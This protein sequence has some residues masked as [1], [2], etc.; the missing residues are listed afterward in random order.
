MLALQQ[1]QRA[2]CA[3]CACSSSSPA[4][5]LAHRP[6]RPCA[7]LAAQQPKGFGGGPSSPSDA[8][9][10]NTSGAGQAAAEPAA[11]PRAAAGAAPSA[12][13]RDDAAL[14]ALEARLKSR[15]AAAANLVPRVKVE[16]AA[17]KLGT[18]QAPGEAGGAAETLYVQF[19]GALFVL[20]LVE[21][22]VLAASVRLPFSFA[23]FVCLFRLPFSFAFFVISSVLSSLVSS[24]RALRLW[25]AHV[26]PLRAPLLTP[27]QPRNT[28]DADENN[29]EN[30]TTKTKTTQ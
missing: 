9:A 21:G 3:A 24:G 1:Q 8:A 12:A 22:L 27:S 19:L 26:V 5:L 6:R 10:P 4:S 30:K 7:R 14:E 16:S 11:K 15:R 18:G 20:I 17:V 29:L 13:G 23:F 2:A 28:N 25:S